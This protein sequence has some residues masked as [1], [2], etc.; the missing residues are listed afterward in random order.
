MTVHA[1]LPTQPEQRF[2]V[3]FY[4]LWPLLTT[5]SRHRRVCVLST[6]LR[7]SRLNNLVA[8]LRPLKTD[9]LS[10]VVPLLQN[11]IG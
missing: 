11:S 1:W 6:Q 4:T 2:K 3:A 5:P 8:V 7:Q 9:I 10:D